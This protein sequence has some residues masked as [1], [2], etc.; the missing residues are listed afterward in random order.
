MLY[1]RG[2]FRGGGRP[3]SG[4]PIFTCKNYLESYI[5][6]YD[7]TYSSHIDLKCLLCV[8]VTLKIQFGNTNTDEYSSYSPSAQSLCLIARLAPHSEILDPP[9]YISSLFKFFVSSLSYFEVYTLLSI[10]RCI[11]TMFSISICTK[12]QF[13]VKNLI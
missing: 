7:N 9:L 5:Y 3:G 8:Y 11:V 13:S 6:H 1:I 2:G 12:L 10:L 4:P